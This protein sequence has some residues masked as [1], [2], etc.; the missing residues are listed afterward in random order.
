[1]ARRVDGQAVGIDGADC[2]GKKNDPGRT[3]G[4]RRLLMEAGL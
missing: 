2:L 1:M 3:G 4:D